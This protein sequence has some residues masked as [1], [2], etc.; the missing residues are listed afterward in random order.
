MKNLF[1]SLLLGSLTLYGASA[2]ADNHR[3]GGHVG[4]SGGGH[5]QSFVRHGGSYGGGAHF[6]SYGHSIGHAYSH[7]PAIVHNGGSS[8]Y[9][10]G[11]HGYGGYGGHGYSG[12][13]YGGGRGWGGYGGGWYGGVYGGYPYG[14]GYG[15]GY[16]GY[17][18]GYGGG[19]YY[20]G[21]DT[22]P[23]YAEPSPLDNS[24]PA[25]GPGGD[26]DG[27]LVAAVQNALSSQGYAAGSTD[28]VMGPATSRAIARYQSDHRLPVTGQID[29]GLMKALGLQ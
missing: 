18:Y 22:G 23:T 14:Y 10:G 26:S 13:Y 4:H 12:H 25:P 16:P 8:H 21:G 28:G 29:A 9:Y 15:N 24:G 2:S 20:D 1:A 6:H 7:G 3:G 5:A 11:G 19:P 27:S 17:G